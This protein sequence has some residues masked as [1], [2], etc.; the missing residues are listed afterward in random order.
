M[1]INLVVSKVVIV[2]EGT[3]TNDTFI[4]FD[5]DPDRPEE[6]ERDLRFRGGL[7]LN[8]TDFTAV[9]TTP[10]DNRAVIQCIGRQYRIG[11]TQ[12]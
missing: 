12:S 5:R 3:V 11:A 4:T 1:Y 9:V 8:G 10:G 7:S 6:F 2:P